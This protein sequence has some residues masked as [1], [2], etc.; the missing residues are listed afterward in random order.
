MNFLKRMEIN[1]EIELLVQDN[2]VGI[3]DVIDFISD[4]SKVHL[5]N[6][7]R[8]L[9]GEYHHLFQ[10]LKKHESKFFEYT[11]MSLVCFEYILN[12]IQINCSRNWYDLH[13]QPIMVEEKLVV[14]LR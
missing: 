10:I 14:T 2:R 1:N 9:Y 13:S 6:Q 7:Q 12:K 4:N 11:R 5:V 8:Y 3:N